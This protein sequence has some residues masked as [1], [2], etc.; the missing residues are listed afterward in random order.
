M[1]KRMYVTLTTALAMALTVALTPASRVSAQTIDEFAHR[2]D[3]TLV[4]PGAPFHRVELP[5]EI[6]RSVTRSDFGDLRLFNA[7]G[8]AVPFAFAN[9]APV[10]A[11]APARTRVPLFAIGEEKAG[12]TTLPDVDVEIRRSADGSL[13]SLRARTETPQSGDQRPTTGLLHRRCEYA[14]KA[15]QRA[16]P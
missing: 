5:A 16:A 10:A 2:A 7:K 11:V 9:E 15:A 3:I 14:Q 13:V 8:E 1:K 6:L 4:N 12:S